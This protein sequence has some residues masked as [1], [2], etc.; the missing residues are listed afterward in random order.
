M[1]QVPETKEAQGGF[2]H[3]AGSRTGEESGDDDVMKISDIVVKNRMKL[4]V[5][6][7]RT[8]FNEG[9]GGKMDD[10]SLHHSTGSYPAEG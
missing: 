5:A 6:E 4:A 9:S 2:H 7:K 1:I 10:L 8:V 3:D